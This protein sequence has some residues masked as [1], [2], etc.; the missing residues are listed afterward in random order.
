M[1]PNAPKPT[2][3]SQRQRRVNESLRHA[4]VEILGRDTP[5][6]LEPFS[7]RI[8]VTE[9]RTSPDLRN[10]LA[11]IMPLAGKDSAT[12]LAALKETTPLIRH[13]LSRRVTLKYLPALRFQLD[14][15]FD[16]AER[17]DRLLKDTL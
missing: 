11:F 14:E 1:K 16:Q 10:A 7:G 9:V 8:T 3:P 4:L 5:A 13:A 12:I 17:I 6:P 15:S 2:G